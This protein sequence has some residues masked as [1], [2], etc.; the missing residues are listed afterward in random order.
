MVTDKI[1]P[2]VMIY[3]DR[4]SQK[5]PEAETRN[6]RRI[7][8]F[9]KPSW[10]DIG[11]ASGTA[12]IPIRKNQT[13]CFEL[14]QTSWKVISAH[15]RYTRV[16]ITSVNKD[17]LIL[18]ATAVRRHRVYQCAVCKVRWRLFLQIAR[19]QR[20]IHTFPSNFQKYVSAAN[21]TSRQ[22]LTALPTVEKTTRIAKNT[23]KINEQRTWYSGTGL[24]FLFDWK[25]T[26]IIVA[27]ESTWSI[28]L[29]ISDI[30]AIFRF[31]AYVY[32]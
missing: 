7:R 24:L 31:R 25:Q 28:Q 5:A 4:V 30:Q 12:S 19:E 3:L 14:K 6:R 21:H 10:F 15:I 32:D 18:C 13:D 16:H 1:P 29:Q 9:S 22:W 17:R 27:P 11:F 20:V 8:C 26:R 2:D 23:T